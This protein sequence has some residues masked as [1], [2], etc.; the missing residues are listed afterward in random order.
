ME[1]S[2]ISQSDRLVSFIIP[3]FE[4]DDIASSLDVLGAHLLK[5]TANR[6]E[7]LVVDDSPARYKAAIRSYVESRRS[8]HGRRLVVRPIDGRMRGKGDAIRI[9]AFASQGAVVFTMDADLPVPLGC[10]D[11]F[12]A[13]ID[14]EGFDVVIGER[15]L[16]RNL[17]EP[18][19]WVLSRILFVAQRVLIFEGTRFHDTQCG[20][21]AFRGALIRD[22]A[23]RQIVCG[24]MYDVEYLYAAHRRGA[25]IARVPVVQNAE[26]R[27]SKIRVLHA[28]LT[29]PIDLVRVKVSGLRRRYDKE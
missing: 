1:E 26:W 19:R 22:L 27:P 18:V 11:A 6:F 2:N 4:E 15:P 24:G 25:A 7:I 3:T 12:L 17:K 28:S 8:L 10:I 20:F 5:S 29:D 23:A 9:G 21:K 16:T 13:L 14:R